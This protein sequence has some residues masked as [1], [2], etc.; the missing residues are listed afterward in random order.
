MEIKLDNLNIPVVFLSGWA[1]DCKIFS[2]ISQHF[3]QA[4]LLNY[5]DCLELSMEGLNDFLVDHIP[6]QSIIIA[7]SFGGSLAID[8]CH[9]YPGKCHKLILIASTPRFTED[10]KW[11]GLTTF[12]SEKLIQ[13]SHENFESV[14]LDFM[15]WTAFPSKNKQ[16]KELLKQ[17][18]SSSCFSVQSLD[19]FLNMDLRVSYQNITQPVLQILGD[20][21]AIVKATIIENLLALNPQAEL[22][23]IAG[24]GHMPFITHEAAC[25]KAINQFLKS[26]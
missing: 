15:K 4:K 9:R 16:Y 1:M 14:L 7:W 20:Q 21:D 18:L 24:A 5:F 11:P 26:C 19:L 12:F 10:Q 2:R 3:K 25:L 8:F 13:R 22:S 6:N 17:H 23:I